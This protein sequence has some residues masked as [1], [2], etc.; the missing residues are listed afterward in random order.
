MKNAIKEKF[1]NNVLVKPLYKL[2]NRN[3]IE[4]RIIISVDSTFDLDG[5]GV[6]VKRDVVNHC[7][8]VLKAKDINRKRRV[9]LCNECDNYNKVIFAEAVQRK[10]TYKNGVRMAKTLD[11]TDNIKTDSINSR[12]NIE[13]KTNK[14]CQADS[15]TE[16]KPTVSKVV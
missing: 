16:V 4:P 6:S 8:K 11:A 3:K 2:K 9:F 1:K 12:V 5:H 15:I 13:D 7:G 10:R 14:L